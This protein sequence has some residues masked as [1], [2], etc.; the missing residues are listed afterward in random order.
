ML[1][2]LDFLVFRIH[3][4]LNLHDLVLYVLQVVVHNHDALSV[5]GDTLRDLFKFLLLLSQLLVDLSVFI[6]CP[7]RNLVCRL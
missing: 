1:F 5:L 4:L 7:V 3:N 6:I 2:G